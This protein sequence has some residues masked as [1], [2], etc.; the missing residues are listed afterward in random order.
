MA[1]VTR[2]LRFYKNDNTKPLANPMRRWFYH[3]LLGGLVVGAGA[4]AAG[5]YQLAAW[6][7]AWHP[8]RGDRMCSAGV[9]E[10]LMILPFNYV[11]HAFGRACES[12]Y[13]PEYFHGA[14]IKAIA[15][16]YGVSLLEERTEEFRT[17]QDFFVRKWKDGERKVS[18]TPVVSPSDG[19]VLSVQEDITDDIL[20]QVKGTTYSVRRLFH[21]PLEPVVESKKRVAVALHLRTQDYHHVIAPSFFTCKETVYIPGALLPHTPAGYHWI[22]SVLPLNERVVLLGRWGN[23]G[24]DKRPRG[25]MAIALVG[26]TLTG[27]IALH[28]DQRIVTNFLKPPKLCCTQTVREGTSAWER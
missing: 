6:E 14:L 9:L 21:A 20:L 24:S 26:R 18:S 15:W 8:C 2:P 11:S 1:L 5:G 27:R 12:T 25:V 16:W 3:Y 22:P 10:I 19:V 13:I 17:L 23:D 4:C 7:A 28:F